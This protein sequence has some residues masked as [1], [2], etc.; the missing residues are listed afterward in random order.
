MTLAFAGDL[1][2]SMCT[3]WHVGVKSRFERIEDRRVFRSRFSYSAPKIMQI[4]DFRRKFATQCLLQ[5]CGI[6]FSIANIF[7]ERNSLDKVFCEGDSEQGFQGRDLWTGSSGQW[8]L[9]G[10]SG[11]GVVDRELWTGSSEQ[12]VLDRELWTKSSGQGVLDKEYQILRNIAPDEAVEY[13]APGEA[14]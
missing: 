7:G 4:C 6:V 12:R 11:Q 5:A 10:S 2:E 8:V 3:Q 14:V 9:D 1:F 13:V